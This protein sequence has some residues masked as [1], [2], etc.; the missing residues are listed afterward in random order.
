VVNL[1][2]EMERLQHTCAAATEAITKR[3]FAGSEATEW[4]GGRV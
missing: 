3:Y 2:R 4:Q 1:P